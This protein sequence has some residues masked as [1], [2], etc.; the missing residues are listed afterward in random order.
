LRAGV[1]ISDAD[2]AA[3][4]LVERTGPERP[5][6][7]HERSAHWQRDQDVGGPGDRVIS[8]RAV[9]R[10]ISLVVGILARPL[11]ARAQEPG[12]TYRL[13]ALFASP[14]DAPQHVALWRGDRHGSGQVW[15]RRVS[16]LAAAILGNPTRWRRESVGGKAR[17]WGWRGVGRTR[18]IRSEGFPQVGKAGSQ[19]VGLVARG[20]HSRD[21]GRHP[22]RLSSH[23]R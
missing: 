1:Q 19:M 15:R 4:Q 3:E 16:Q 8:R 6:A 5:A 7:H 9:L 17:W 22:A 18:L 11:A 12:R 21:K 13:G 14:R 10:G 2:R 20:Q 23:S